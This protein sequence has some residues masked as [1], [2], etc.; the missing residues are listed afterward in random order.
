MGNQGSA[1]PGLRAGVERL[2]AGVLGEVREVHVWTNRPVWPQG[3]TVKDDAHKVPDHLNWDLWLGC[4]VDRP[5]HPSYLPFNWRG[6]HD[7]GTGALGD[8]ACHTMNLVWRGLDLGTPIRATVETTERFKDTYP[9]GARV[10]LTFPER[11]DQPAVDLTWWEGSMR[12]PADLLD[13]ALGKMGGSGTL[14]IGSKGQMFSANDYQVSQRWHPKQLGEVKVAQTEP[15]APRGPERGQIKEWL[16]AAKA[17]EQAWTDFSVAGPFTEAVLVGDLAMRTAQ[18]I[19]WDT[20]KM[21]ARGLDAA[22]P[23]VR[24]SYRKGFGIR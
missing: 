20:N 16:D 18:A 2:R 7:F 5:Y 4:A 11:G 9:K 8:M 17:G 22:R 21:E 23:L 13:K 3:F 24:R 14:V 6:F 12:P 10:T 15:R 19:R 1:S